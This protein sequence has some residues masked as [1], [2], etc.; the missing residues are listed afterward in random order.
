MSNEQDNTGASPTRPARAIKPGHRGMRGHAPLLGRAIAFE[1]TLERDLLTHL[2]LDRSLTEIVGQPVTIRYTDRAGRR[3]RYT[4]DYFTRHAGPPD[5]AYLIEVKHRADLFAGWAELR[6][7][8]MAGRRHAR[9]N[10]WRFLILT[11]KE[12]RGPDLGNA[13]FLAR[14]RDWP[15]DERHE[16]HLVHRLAIIGPADP[17]KLLVAAYASEANRAAALGYLWKMVATG[18]IRADL[19]VPL[20]METEIW[21]DYDSDWAPYDPYSYGRTGAAWSAAPFT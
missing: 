11:E 12:L 14:F 1:S 19:A 16:E 17:A 21:I 9:E 5:R 6:P 10:G 15:R 7:G 8:I 18:R 20:T 2:S 13:A 4:P 3:R